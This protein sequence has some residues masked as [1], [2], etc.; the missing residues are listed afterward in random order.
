MATPS[1]RDRLVSSAVTML[2]THGADGFGMSALL[3]HSSVARRSMYQYFPE[4]KAQLLSE[5]TA[6]AGKGVC[7]YLKAALAEHH[8][9]DALDLWAEQWKSSM[10]ASDYALGCPLAAASLSAHEYP[11]AAAESATALSRAA[12]LIAEALTRD[13]LDADEAQSAGRVAVSSVEGAIIVARATRS[14]QPFDDFAA[15]A[16]AV[17]GPRLTSRTS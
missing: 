9:L 2:R 3:Q 10:A 17:W 16:R 15:H 6:T 14:V 7:A 11:D 13:G 4:G 12:T 5:A 1:V 8:T